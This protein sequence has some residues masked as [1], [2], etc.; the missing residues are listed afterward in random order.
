VTLF[1][2][3]GSVAALVREDWKVNFRDWT[4]PGF[5]ALAVHRFGTWV[6]E[7]RRTPV[8]WVLR[9]VHRMMFRYVRNHYGIEL[10]ATVTVGRRVI[11]GH[12]HGIV[13]HPN[14]V[15]GDEVLIHQ[16]VTLGAV[17]L[18]RH[19]EAPTIGRG[20]LLGAG[21]VILG[22]VT[23]GE[24]AKIGPNAVIMFDVPADASVFVTTPR[25]LQT[26]KAA[27]AS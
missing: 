12:Q 3:E 21:A 18:E 16:N 15:I 19:T 23:I 10:P 8:R 6:G 5:R 7:L 13:I 24:R 22:G 26:V 9:R 17:S 25:M 11:I 4:M 20:A 27:A 2:N 1:G 14:A